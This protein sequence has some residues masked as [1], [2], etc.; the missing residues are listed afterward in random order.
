MKGLAAQNYLAGNAV[1][2]TTKM[3]S[4]QPAA[5]ANGARITGLGIIGA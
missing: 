3:P 2:L 5:T 4:E 1:M